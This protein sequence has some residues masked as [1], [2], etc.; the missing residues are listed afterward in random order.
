VL[1]FGNPARATA[2]MRCAQTIVAD[3]ALNNLVWR[4]E[5]GQVWLGDTIRAVWP[6]ATA[7][8]AAPR[9]R[10]SKGLEEP[11]PRRRLPLG[12]EPA[13]GALRNGLH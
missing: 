5:A 4:D 3:L 12:A 11:S 1:I 8:R 10:R 13:S 2:L 7:P 6:D 9:R